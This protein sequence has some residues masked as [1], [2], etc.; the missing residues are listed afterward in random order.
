MILGILGTSNVLLVLEIV[1]ALVLMH[2]ASVLTYVFQHLSVGGEAGYIQRD[3]S[4]YVG[5]RSSDILK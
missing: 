3:S 2:L 1:F 4:L 5:W